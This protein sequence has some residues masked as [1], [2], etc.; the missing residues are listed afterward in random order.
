M[1]IV[2]SIFN[3]LKEL[4]IGTISKGLEITEEKIVSAKIGCGYYQGYLFGRPVPYEEFTRLDLDNPTE[5]K[6]TA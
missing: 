2:R 1:K 4:E 6:L 5:Q 3:R